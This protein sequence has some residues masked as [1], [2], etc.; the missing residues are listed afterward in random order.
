MV[1]KDS[2]NTSSAR[3]GLSTIRMPWSEVARVLPRRMSGQKHLTRRSRNQT[4]MEEI[5]RKPHGRRAWIGSAFHEPCR[6]PKGNET[7]GLFPFG[8]PF[9]PRL[10]THLTPTERPKNGALRAHEALPHTSPA[11][12]SP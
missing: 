5:R 12:A 8:N 10:A 1:A 3:A 11:G 4:G 9:F 6:Y 7:Y 2:S